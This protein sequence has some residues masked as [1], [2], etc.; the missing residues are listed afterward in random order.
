MA[1][2]GGIASVPHADTIGGHSGSNNMG[3]GAETLPGIDG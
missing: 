1:H 3:H 2:S